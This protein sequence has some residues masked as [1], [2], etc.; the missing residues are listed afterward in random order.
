M[1]ASEPPKADN[2]MP[3]SPAMAVEQ[4]PEKADDWAATCDLHVVLKAHDP[5]SKDK[6]YVVPG[7]SQYLST[8]FFKAP[9]T[10]NVQMLK[11][12]PILDNKKV[13]H[14]WIL[15]ATDSTLAKDGDQR[16]S[17]DVKSEPLGGEAFV[18]SANPGSTNLELPP[19]VGIRVPSGQNLLLELEIHYSNTANEHDEEDASGM[20]L[21]MTT[22]PRPIEAAMH[23]LGRASFE[24]PPHKQTDITSTC[25]PSG[26][27]K[28]VH[29]VGATPHMHLHGAH[30]K[31]VLNRASGEKVTL[32]EKPFEFQEQRSYALPEDRATPDIIVNP[33]D[34][35]TATCGYDNTTDGTIRVG[36]NSEDE[37]C[38]LGLLAWPAGELHNSLGA[39]LGPLSP[40]GDLADVFCI[41]P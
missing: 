40:F 28:P 29:I 20:E 14:H 16:G 24:L 13:V 41:E 32:L 15:W 10:G 33:G 5:A 23:S 17:P 8:F 6:K 31:L 21:C 4:T 12:R 38:L 27:T 11:S 3:D 25:R 36:E 1:A 18:T 9:W 26:L 37:M 19:D 39:L 30:S 7:G 35:L 34:T 22:K 2:A